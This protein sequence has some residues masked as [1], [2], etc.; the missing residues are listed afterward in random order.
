MNTI[1]VSLAWCWMQ[2]LVVA[3]VA[4]GLSMLATRRS[5]AAGA[6][7]AWVGVLASLTL[8]LFA[9]IPAP[10]WA[11]SEIRQVKSSLAVA[12]EP[13][14]HPTIQADEPNDAGAGWVIDLQTLRRIVASVEQSQTVVAGHIEIGR[15]IVGVVGAGILLGLARIACGLWAIAILRRT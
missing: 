2:T 1:V 13:A 9:P 12:N 10:R 14:A 4:I 11:V 7:I 15:V 3:G 8:V 5:P 6:A